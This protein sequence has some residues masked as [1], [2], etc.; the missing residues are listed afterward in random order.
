MEPVLDVLRDCLERDRAAGVAFPA[1]WDAAVEAA[2]LAAPLPVERR[3][4][5]AALTSTWSAWAR[6]YTGAAAP[7]LA[8]VCEGL[9]VAA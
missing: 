4:W 8:L 3:D 1:A 7:R 5:G 6:A 2:L 9:A